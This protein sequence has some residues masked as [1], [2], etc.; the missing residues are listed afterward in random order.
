ALEVGKRAVPPGLL[1]AKLGQLS[2]GEGAVADGTEEQT[3]LPRGEFLGPGERIERTHALGDLLV[4]AVLADLAVELEEL[5]DDRGVGVR[6]RC[7]VDVGVEPRRPDLLQPAQPSLDPAQLGADLVALEGPI[8]V[9]NLVTVSKCE[10]VS[11][12]LPALDKCAVGGLPPVDD[13]PAHLIAFVLQAEDEVDHRLIYLRKR[14]RLVVR[15]R[16]SQ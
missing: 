11:S 16:G 9:R 4:L 8:E 5:L 3:A 13:E 14:V 10:P 12:G 2:W 7:S 15:V 1:V 6:G